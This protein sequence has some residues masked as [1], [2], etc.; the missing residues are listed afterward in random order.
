MKTKALLKLSLITALIGTFLVIILANNLEPL[1][2]EISNINENMIDEWVKIQGNVT[3]ERNVGG[4]TILT[5]YDGSGGIR[6]TLRKK[7]D[8]KFEGYEVVILGKIFE[9]KNEIEIEI[10]KISINSYPD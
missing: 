1:I 10:S 2:I 4:L 8:V 9:Y 3:N 7:T 6:A 5:I